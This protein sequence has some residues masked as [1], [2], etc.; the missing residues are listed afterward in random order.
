AE[1]EARRKADLDAKQKAE[2]EAREKAESD[3]K[4]EIQRELK[5]EQLRK[6]KEEADRQALKERLQEEES[7]AS[8][9]KAVESAARAWA[10]TYIKPRVQRSWLR[11]P[12]AKNG[13]SC[14][15][16]VKTIPG[17]EVA[18]VRIIK[19][20]GDSAFDRSAEAAVYKA[21]PLPMPTDSKVEQQLRSFTF[22]FK[23]E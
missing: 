5:A 2:A 19:S 3:R 12:S 11:P 16:Q 20:S 8:Q 21:S 14:I 10:E 13:M 1:A 7:D 18:S 22:T 9:Q 23:P 17:G 15:I 6:A 4:A